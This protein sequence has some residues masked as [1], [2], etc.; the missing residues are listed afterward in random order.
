MLFL[1]LISIS[2]RSYCTAL[3]CRPPGVGGAVNGAGG[4][5]TGGDTGAVATVN[6]TGTVTGEA[7]MALSVIVPL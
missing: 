2:D 7:P 4:G 5:M 3:M 6:V 1:F